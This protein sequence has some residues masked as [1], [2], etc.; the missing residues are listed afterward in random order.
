VNI[1]ITSAGRR[2]SL[3]REFKN[4]LKKTTANGIV[5]VADANPEYSAASQIANTYFHL[6]IVSDDKY[7]DTLLEIAQANN[8]KVIIPTIDTELQTLATN[9]DRFL[10]EGIDIII[11]DLKLIEAC[12]DKRLTQGLFESI[13]IETPV[14]YSDSNYRYPVFAKPIDGSSSKNLY[15]IQNKLELAVIQD[16]NLNLVFMEYLDPAYHTEYTIDIYYD[17]NSTMKCLVP[18]KRIEVRSGEVNKAIT[19][20]GDLYNKLESRFAGLSGARGCITAQ[21]FVSNDFQEVYG[22]EVN[23]RFGGGYPLSYHAGANYPSWI[24]QEYLFNRKVQYFKDWH[25]NLLMLRYDQEV[26]VDG[27]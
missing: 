3:L 19:E 14:I 16:K 15:L 4:E 23:P 5:F 22:I 21:V 7:V 20:K 18:R 17:R 1:L 6:P 10:K 9:R 27:N 24:I 25:D 11:S 26:I 12:R 13:S 2:V 8:I